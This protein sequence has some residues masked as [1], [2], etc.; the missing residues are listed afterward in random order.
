MCFTQI[1]PN[2]CLINWTDSKTFVFDSFLASENMTI[3]LSIGHDSN[4]W[5]FGTGAIYI[6]LLYYTTSSI[7]LVSQHIFDPGSNIQRNMAVNYVPRM[8]TLFLY[9]S[10]EQHSMVNP[11]LSVPADCRI[12]LTRLYVVRPLC[13]CSKIVSSH[14]TSHNL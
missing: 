6:F 12:K 14:I 5:R 3:F 10:I 1:Y 2:N 9:L 8:R 7:I 11:S 4:G 13:L